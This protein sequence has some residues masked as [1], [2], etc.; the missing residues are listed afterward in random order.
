MTAT[1]WNPSDAAA[2]CS[3]GGGNLNVTIGTGAAEAGCRATVSKSS[4]KW[5]WEVKCVLGSENPAIGVADGSW[6]ISTQKLGQSAGSWAIRG[7]GS[8]LTN[9]SSTSHPGF[10]YT[11]GD[12]INIAWDADAGKLWFGKNGTWI[13]SG[14]PAAGTNATYTS[15]TGTLFAAINASSVTSS[16]NGTLNAGATAF[17]NTRPSGF[18]G[19]DISDLYFSSTDKDNDANISNGNL[20]MTSTTA[21]TPGAGRFIGA[22][23]PLSHTGGKYWFVIK[24]TH[25][26][27]KGTNS[28]GI[29]DG[30]STLTEPVGLEA[31]SYGYQNY[32]AGGHNHADSAGSPG[33]LCPIW[34]TAPAYV[35]VAVDL[36]GGKIWFGAYISGAWSWG[37]G[38][39]DAGTNPVFTGISSSTPFFPMVSH[40]GD[41]QTSISVIDNGTMF[42]TLPNISGFT[43]WGN[44]P[45]T[46]VSG[47][48]AVTETQDT[49]AFT[50]N[51]SN[52][53][54]F[55]LTETQDT[56]SLHASNLTAMSFAVTEPQ[57]VAL[58]NMTYVS[59][60]TGNMVVTETADTLAATGTIV[61]AV[62]G[63]LIVTEDPDTVEFDAATTAPTPCLIAV[64]SAGRIMKSLDHGV[65]WT[66]TSTGAGVQL[67]GITQ[68]GSNG[69]WIAVG[70]TGKI[71]K[72]DDLSTWVAKTSPVTSDLNYCAYGNGAVVAV[73]NLGKVVRSVD[74]ETWT[75]AA[76]LGGTLNRVMYSSVFGLFVAV[77]VAGKLYT[78]SDGTSWTVRSTPIPTASLY[79]LCEAQG[80]VIV[81]S[82][83]K[84][85]KATD[86]SSW[87]GV[88]PPSTTTKTS[89]AGS[90]SVFVTTANTRKA[91]KSTNAGVSWTESTITTFTAIFND[92]VWDG[93]RFVMVGNR[94]FAVTSQTA[95]LNSTDGATWNI[96]APGTTENLRAI[97]N[98]LVPGSGDFAHGTISAIE[99]ADSVN[100]SVYAQQIN[101]A[102]FNVEEAPDIFIT[103]NG[104]F[105]WFAT[106]DTMDFASFV[107]SQ[108]S[109]SYLAA[110]EDADTLV[111]QEGGGGSSV[112][113][114]MAQE[115]VDEIVTFGAEIF[116]GGTLSLYTGSQPTSPE[117]VPT[118]TLIGQ[119]TLAALAWQTAVDGTAVGINLPWV[120]NATDTGIVGWFRLTSSDASNVI[121]GTVSAASGDGD[122]LMSVTSANTGD[123]LDVTA[124]TFRL[125]FNGG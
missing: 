86:P 3:F 87:T 29:S 11:D 98:G 25:D 46:A 109:S 5:Y 76:T 21:T 12:Y 32:G 95:I 35:G 70:S 124:A 36:T 56:A 1:T 52:R 55:A 96:V 10:N 6:N 28:I 2:Q 16:A 44:L 22:R 114:A 75:L 94:D 85:L 90:D 69:A 51:V 27:T 123:E 9:N 110:T 54:T 19:F 111:L 71:Y 15:V 93:T 23:S 112:T 89:V 48:M 65:T 39:P 74:G 105:M 108:T 61:S 20:T 30:T 91:T 7:D 49:G 43:P 115:T 34:P 88:T 118:G 121:D 101:P 120:G 68:L 92:I 125:T 57:D 45:S 117:D 78:S 72:S 64:G 38:V 47:S 37:T 13:A 81:T 73:G 41:A 103:A 82:S 59:T 60:V 4:G 26:L 113:I 42:Q 31:S 18:F 63:D 102:S 116:N 106:T 79:G 77:G 107:G 50:G 14:D 66:A 119:I 122:L 24:A 33:S 53:A 83:T 8:T 99:D 80:N 17:H 67:N 100:F 97:Y 40:V 104:S 62:A 84:F 58:L